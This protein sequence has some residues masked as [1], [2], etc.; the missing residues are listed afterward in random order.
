MK[1]IDRYVL[2]ACAFLFVSCASD[3][4][5]RIVPPSSGEGGVVHSLNAQALGI[6]I[7]GT[8]AYAIRFKTGES[9]TL[10]TGARFRSQNTH[11]YGNLLIA[12]YAGSAAEVAMKTA[13]I[14]SITDVASGKGIAVSDL[15]QR[16]RSPMCY[17]TDAKRRV[18]ANLDGCDPGP[19]ADCSGPM[20]PGGW[21]SCSIVSHH[22][23]GVTDSNTGLG[24][25]IGLFRSL[26]PMVT[27]QYDFTDGRSRVISMWRTPTRLM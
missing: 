25:G 16:G 26:D 15:A 9:A 17:A 13:A 21:L 10:P 4:D 14:A 20:A 8:P 23:C 2:A 7:S 12:H 19:C 22:I 18:T 3:R 5:P 27:C 1:I 11:R 24:T 6:P